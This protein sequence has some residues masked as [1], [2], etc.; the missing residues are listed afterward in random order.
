MTTKLLTYQEARAIEAEVFT[1]HCCQFCGGLVTGHFHA[2]DDI[3][4]CEHESPP[5][6]PDCRERVCRFLFSKLVAWR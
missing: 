4:K 6:C 3:E 2:V 5:V 1:Y